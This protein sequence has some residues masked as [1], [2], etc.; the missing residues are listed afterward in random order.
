MVIAAVALALAL[1]APGALP[2][3]E[4]PAPTAPGAT[5][6]ATPAPV[7][8]APG[9]TAP[10]AP[11]PG[12]TAPAPG[13]TAE[14]TPAA[15]APSPTRDPRL[16]GTMPVYVRAGVSPA[17]GSIVG[18]GYP[19]SV[20]FSAPVTDR[21]AAQESVSVTTSRP[22]PRGGVWSWV[23]DRTMILR[24]RG[25]YW[26]GNTEIT[27]RVGLRGTY[28][29]SAGRGR[30]YVG[31]TRQT[32]RYSTAR[33]FIAVIDDKDLVMRVRVG[34]KEVKRIPV[35]LG[36]AGFI[37]RSGVK[38]VHEKYEVKRMTSAGMNLPPEEE[39][40]V[41]SPFAL[42]L[43]PT[44]EFIHGAPWAVYRLGRWN[45]SHGCTN[46]SVADAQ[47]MYERAIT[48]DVV[49]TYGTSEQMEPWNGL[50]GSW[51]VP[52]STWRS[53]SYGETRLNTLIPT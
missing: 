53:R 6:P 7:T 3:A 9:A 8:P 25:D 51:N 17:N 45:G 42:R 13:T 46:L 5:A 34:G 30:S 33:R 4:T 16:R 29:G 50:G 18:V 22:L 15:P 1:L 26:P 47:W 21:R 11:A 38:V 20:R 44:G 39:Y 52:W 43:T 49:E 48:G 28:L 27:V 19:L 37:T 36:K 14:P 31:T 32:V 35:S 40:D 10:A 2:P 41:M 24:P 23:D 12:M